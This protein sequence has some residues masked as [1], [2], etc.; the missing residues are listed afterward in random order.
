MGA[1]LPEWPRMM[2]RQTAAAY[3]DISVAELE[4]EIFS[5]RLPHPIKLGNGLHWSR[6][7]LDAHVERLTGEAQ[8]DDW[9]SRTKLYG[10]G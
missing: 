4:R 9:R 6:A 8:A 7:Q 2:K 3:L 10:N 1:H 5:G